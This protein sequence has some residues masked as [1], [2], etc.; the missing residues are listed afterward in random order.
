MI[1]T[2]KEIVPDIGYGLKERLRQA[3]MDHARTGNLTTYKE[4]ADRLELAPPHKIHR[5]AE[6]LEARMKEDVAAGRPMLS[7]LCVSKMQPGIPGRGFFLT[8]EVLGIFF[9]DPAG[10]EASAFHA[11]EL[12]RVF[13]FYESQPRPLV[14]SSHHAERQVPAHAIDEPRG[15]VKGA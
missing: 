9:G 3:L 15:N 12:K 4:L 13:S 10:L 14:R 1:D 6:A 5:I 2:A 11:I 8:A 7:A